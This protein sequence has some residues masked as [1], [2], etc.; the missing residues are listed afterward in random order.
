MDF[1]HKAF[2]RK[3]NAEGREAA[4][5]VFAGI[6]STQEAELDQRKGFS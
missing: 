1:C 6:F 5:F 4:A 2:L 3:N